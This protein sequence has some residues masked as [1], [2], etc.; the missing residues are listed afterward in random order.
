MAMAGQLVAQGQ[1]E[2]Q[3]HNYPV[4]FSTEVGKTQALGKKA[5]ESGWLSPTQL[6]EDYGAT[7]A[8]PGYMPMFQDSSVFFVPSDQATSQ[9]PFSSSWNLFGTVFQPNDPLYELQTTGWKFSRFTDYTCDSISFPYSYIRQV[10]QIMVDSVMVDVVDTVFVHFFENKN[11]TTTWFFQNSDEVFSIPIVANYDPNRLGPN[12]ITYVD[13]ILLTAAAATDSM[14]EESINLA[15]I[16]SAIDAGVSHIGSDNTNNEDNVIGVAI[17]FKTM[18]PYSFG[19]T[20]LSYND[21][22]VP[23]K[24]FNVFGTVN[25]GNSGSRVIQ[26]EFNNNSFVTNRQVRYGQSVGSIKGYLPTLQSIGWQRDF[27]FPASFH[28]VGANVGVNEYA[29]VLGLKVYPNPA[30]NGADLVISAENIK[31]NRV[32]LK[33]IDVVGNVVYSSVDQLT[34]DTYHIPTATLLP[35]IYF[36]SLSADGVTAT[37]KVVITQ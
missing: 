25:Y 12:D 4:K 29:K 8:G 37:Q 13:T 1:L 3:E 19:D 30:N 36:V 35:G 15:S 23:D 24:K 7:F 32:N 6:M 31:G 5:V 2:Y 33:M 14:L 28:V 21:Q 11:I 26:T 10:D 20:L 18:L 34:A 16:A 17:S 22:I 9:T 27:Y